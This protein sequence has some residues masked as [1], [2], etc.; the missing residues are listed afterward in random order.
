V[1]GGGGGGGG[2]RF[3][4]FVVYH[5]TGADAHAVY[6]NSDIFLFKSFVLKAEQV[7]VRLVVRFH[8]GVC[9]NS[10]FS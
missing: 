3:V 1:G 8:R 10:C 9:H 7:F 4:F 5:S 2:T 6:H